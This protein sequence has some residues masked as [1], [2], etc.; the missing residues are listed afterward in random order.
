M[1]TKT[2]EEIKEQ[3]RAQ[4]EQTREF[5]QWVR[6]RYGVRVH[7]WDKARRLGLD[8][9]EIQGRWIL[10]RYKR[11][12]LYK[13]WPRNSYAP[14]GAPPSGECDAYGADSCSTINEETKR[15]LNLLLAE[16]LINSYGL[17]TLWGGSF[18]CISTRHED[19]V[20][21]RLALPDTDIVGY[22]FAIASNY[23]AE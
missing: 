10:R 8:Y 16:K 11:V 3:E 5:E 19:A 1:S 2:K 20:R 17:R 15:K 22:Y 23:V 14:S 12:D 21:Q 18:L 13:Y 6:R 9:Y 7:D 4:E